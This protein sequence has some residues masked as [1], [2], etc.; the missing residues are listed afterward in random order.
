MPRV[1]KKGGMS[2]AKSTKVGGIRTPFTAG[3][4]SK[5][6]KLGGKRK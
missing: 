2:G 1:L 6:G 4:A 5:G 3:I